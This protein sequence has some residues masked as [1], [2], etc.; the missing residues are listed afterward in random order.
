[1]NDFFGADQDPIFQE[2]MVFRNHLPK[3]ETQDETHGLNSFTPDEVEQMR[4]LQNKDFLPFS[5]QEL[6]QAL[7]SILGIVIAYAYDQRTT[8]GDPT[9]ESAWTLRILSPVLSWLDAPDHPIEALTIAMHRM[10]AYPYLRHLALSVTALEDAVE[11]LRGGKRAILRSL[12]YVHRVL[13][14]SEQYYLLNRLYITDMCVWVQQAEP[15]LIQHFLEATQDALG[16]LLAK[17]PQDW[18]RFEI[19]IQLD[20]DDDDHDADIDVNI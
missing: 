11:I 18:I 10:L 2:A 14:K 6:R 7:C 15:K 17:E 1:M 16:E 3:S 5:P 9:V 19:A 8:Q 20:D 4:K 13:Q 12:L